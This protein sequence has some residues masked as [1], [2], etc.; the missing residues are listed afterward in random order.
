VAYPISKST[1]V[2]KTLLS[3]DVFV[4]AFSSIAA[5]FALYLSLIILLYLAIDPAG[6]TSAQAPTKFNVGLCIFLLALALLFADQQQFT[7][8]K[9][10]F[11]IGSACLV[12][13]VAGITLSQY[14]WNFNAGIDELF[15]KVSNNTSPYAGRMSALSCVI[16]LVLAFMIL[17]LRN[18]R[19]HLLFQILLIAG[20]VLLAVVVLINISVI[21]FGQFPFF[22]AT[23]LHSTVAV[24]FLY[25]GVFFSFPLSYLRFS[26]E[27][28][29]LG[30]FSFALLLMVIVF[31]AFRTSDRRSLEAAGLVS[32]THRLLLQA[33]LVKADAI[34]LQNH[35]RGYIITGGEAYLESFNK[36]VDQ[37]DNHLRLMDAEMNDSPLQQQR[38]DSLRL[39]VHR[40][41][42]S[43]RDSIPFLA[44]AE[45]RSSSINQAVAAGEAMT[46][47]IKDLL[48]RIRE[49]E[50]EKLDRQQVVNDKNITTTS[51]AVSLLQIVIGIMIAVSFIIIFINARR[52]RK[53]EIAL[54]EMNESLEMKVLEKAKE[55]S[56]RETQYR[57]LIENMQEGV[58][59]IGFDWRYLMVNTA[60]MQQRENAF[61]DLVGYTVFEKNPGIEFSPTFGVLDNCMTDRVPARVEYSNRNGFFKLS[62]QPVPEGLFILSMDVTESKIF[63]E[64]LKRSQAQLAEAHRIARLASWQWDVNQGLV[65]PSETL[66]A[67]LDA[68][69]KKP[70][71]TQDFMKLMDP[72]DQQT[73][74]RAIAAAVDNGTDLKTGFG[75]KGNAGDLRYLHIT[76]KPYYET[77]NVV[78]GFTGTIQD[79]TALK[80][81]EAM[82][83]QLNR[84]LEKK[85]AELQMSNAE[86]ERFAFIASHDLQ[87]PL[88]MVS[89]F[90]SLLEEE[91]KEILDPA[92]REYIYFAMD[93]AERMKTLIQALLEYSRLGTGKL[94][95]TEVDCNE[96]LGQVKQVLEIPLRESAAQLIVH[97]LP[98][99]KGAA[100]QL[101]QLFQNLV[102]NAV[103]YNQQPQPVI[104]ISCDSLEDKWQFSIKDNGIG[105]DPKYFE[106]IF[107]IFQ[108]LHDNGK[109]TGTGIGL[110]VCRRIAEKHGGTI[111]VASEPGVGSTFYFTISKSAA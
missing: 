3:K 77:A 62:I 8:F 95:F 85:A 68:D 91:T 79:V 13:L 111:W 88:R 51:K 73:L 69:T 97:P 83:Q 32:H 101:Q 15:V 105:I 89:S 63:L 1:N 35:L 43:R 84:N 10:A 45:I 64:E 42:G 66:L 80:Q 24:C 36:K 76:G 58:Q 25:A 34:E 81:S 21:N 11:G 49:H 28:K 2:L 90:L 16:F 56:G 17:F 33:D 19:F 12:V 54:Q 60:Y 48:Q 27:K 61:E 18:R 9:K 65:N 92:A 22:G 46:A 74:N 107:I 50:V 103:K 53:A 59:L 104:E 86:L 38:I 99:V 110:A 23:T 72:D 6:I 67:L 52:R 40:F 30:A 14:I 106:K 75:L 55:L 93:G 4:K 109:Y 98:V 71:S 94:K 29:M 82:L 26:F 7:G 100:V 44:S 102:A 78:A 57:F 108:R 31:F 47:E 87:E 41:I 5:A 96:T 39:L 70:F 37:V 20:L